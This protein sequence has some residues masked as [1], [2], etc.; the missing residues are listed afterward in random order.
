VRDAQGQKM[1]KSKGNTADPQE[2][3]GVYGTD[4]VRFTMAILAAPGND[5]HLAPKRMEGYRAFA[6]KLWNASRFV[7]MRVGEEQPRAFR[8]EDLTLVD[9]WILSRTQATVRDVQAALSAFR[10]DHAADILYHFVW[11]QFCDW[12]IE[13]VKP[14]LPQQRES[15]NPRFETARAV[16]LH[17]LGTTLRL[18][19][20]FM[21][22]ITEELW[23]KLPG[24]DSYLAV[25]AWPEEDASYLDAIAEADV[26][27]L[28][29]LVVKIRNV[30]AENSIEAHKRIKLLLQVEGKREEKLIRSQSAL[31]GSLVRAESVEIVDE[32]QSGAA[33]RGVSG[34]VHIMIPLE[35]LVDIGDARGR[36][37]RELEKVDK[38]LQTRTRK[39]NNMS[40]IERA[41]AEVVERERE[42]Q[43]ELA[44]RK[45]KLEANLAM[46]DGAAGPE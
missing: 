2:V 3:H 36:L 37:Q 5:I 6:N 41:P 1:S 33:A 43:R 19:H 44:E 13:F 34:K 45:G 9:R 25:A 24:N 16:L 29:T 30:R 12:Y 46:L 38:E 17:V 23:H 4:A 35:G 11:G 40:F 26:S 18:L 10:F 21:P 14:D 28:Q 42:L 15:E 7:L 22:F 27:L 8:G 20:P 39:L 31:I 32:L